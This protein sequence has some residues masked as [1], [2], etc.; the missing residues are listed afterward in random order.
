VALDRNKVLA[1]AQKQ[2]SKGNYDKAIA[3]YRKLVEEDPKD[4]RTW[5]KIGD[6]Y[7]RK[8]SR[9]EA[10]ETYGR[11]AEHYA[12]QGF[13]LKAVAVYKQILKL[14]PSRVD[15]CVRLGEM[16]EQ[17]QLA[18]DALTT[19]EQVVAAYARS[20]EVE[21]A[22]K[23]LAKMTELDPENIPVRIKYAEALSKAGKTAPAAA[24]FERGARLLKAQ[25]RLDD[26]TKVAERLLY[27]RPDDVALA[28]ELATM[29]LE[30]SDAKRA[31][32]KLQ[33]CFK[34]NPRDVQTL[35]LLAQAFHQLGQTPKT[36]SVYREVARIHQEANRADERAKVLKRILELDPSD[37]EARQALAGY[38]PASSPP[39][40]E[41]SRPLEMP[42]GA[43][44]E[45]VAPAAGPSSDARSAPST[46]P[47]EPDEDDSLMSVEPDIDLDA[48]DDPDSTEI[49]IVDEDEP[50][51]SEVVATGRA[52]ET[53][54]VSN[55]PSMPPEVALEA[56]V[57]RLLTECEVFARYGLKSKII[58]QL[59]EVVELAPTHV[60]ARERLKDVYLETGRTDDAVDQLRA[61]AM[62][63]TE[64]RPQLAQLY[65]RQ[66]L[67]LD[68]ENLYARNHLRASIVPGPG[69]IPPPASVTT[70]DVVDEEDEVLFVDDEGDR[71]ADESA[72]FEEPIVA[73]AVEP[74]RAES[75]ESPPSLEVHAVVTAV[76]VPPPSAAEDEEIGPSTAEV[77]VPELRAEHEGGAELPAYDA[78]NEPAGLAPMSPEEFEAAPVQDEPIAPPA[79]ASMGEPGEVEEILDEADFYIAQGLWDE[80][81]ETIE[82]AL[83]GHPSHPLLLDKLEEI[84]D[85]ARA[86][87]T[88]AEPV[89]EPADDETFALAEK[90]AEE[91]DE[92]AEQVGSDVLDIDNVF[93]QFKKGVEEQ[94]EASDTETHYDLGIAYK[95]MGLVDDAVSE[96]RLAMANPARECIAQTM[97]GLCYLEQGR[98]E[99]A[100][101][102]F[103]KGLAAPTRSAREELGLFFE[104]GN[105][106][107]LLRDAAA[108]LRYF[109]QVESVDP[110][111]R[112]VADR[113]RRLTEH[114]GPAGA[115]QDDVEQA[116]DDLFGDD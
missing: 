1:A 71:F 86:S 59:E 104:L 21:L 47:V 101:A 93:A 114:T 49:L 28:R 112:G 15:I 64:S 27:H 22:L 2:L 74:G 31:L 116:F 69:S 41:R 3:E 76:D 20:G 96:F 70:T 83:E 5:L 92:S 115:R 77:A 110:G 91:L 14:D 50:V 68:P 75:T 109:R 54:A 98:V 99:E 72:T 65:V 45:S 44:V 4:V 66:I 85:A 13:F 56:K 40:R 80:A 84:E 82:D 26:Y 52:P 35:D 107:E 60:E 94:I 24:E 61:L 6:I 18:T 25:G 43:V 19:Y 113:I 67:E 9:K 32:A 97:I 51:E 81:R 16:Y 88:V 102:H 108:A 87:T 37:A 63:F 58:E 17:L 78:A 38:A 62:I 100:V 103:E 7:T 36:I 111:F 57:A 53:S 12:V 105:A 90:L 11:V 10:V 46:R 39:A 55:S 73:R 95:E 42:P 79:A 30:R 29:Y 34:T 23:T 33:V 106:H 89:V 48:P 8:G